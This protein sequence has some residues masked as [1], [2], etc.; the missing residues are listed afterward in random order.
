MAHVEEG[1]AVMDFS[2]QK[3]MIITSGFHS[4]GPQKLITTP[5]YTEFI[6]SLFIRAFMI[7]LQIEKSK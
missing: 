4:S 3:E 7:H 2:E 1:N 5:F 6:V